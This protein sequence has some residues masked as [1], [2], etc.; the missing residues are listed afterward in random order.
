MQ[1]NR[2]DYFI[3]IF[4]YQNRPLSEHVNSDPQFSHLKWQ[5]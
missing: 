4:N 2:L 1:V 3:L 5:L